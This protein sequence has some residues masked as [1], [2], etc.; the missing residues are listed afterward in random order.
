M[1]PAP[2]RLKNIGRWSVSHLF[3]PLGDAILERSRVSN[4]FMTDE[5]A[6]LRAMDDRFVRHLAEAKIKGEFPGERL[7]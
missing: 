3:K 4:R 5:E 7:L 1:R 2:F 6:R